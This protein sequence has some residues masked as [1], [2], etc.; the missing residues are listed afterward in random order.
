MVFCDRFIWAE[1]WFFTWS[2]LGSDEALMQAQRLVEA[3]KTHP[4]VS[5]KAAGWSKVVQFKPSDGNPFY[6]HSTGSGLTVTEGL[7]PNPSAT[8]E[9]SHQDLVS[10]LRGE[11]DAVKAFFSGRIK[12][13][14]D[15]FAA[16]ELNSLFSTLLKS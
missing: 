2:G 1:R 5:R 16:Q 14:G 4:E 7:H 11:L 9:S 6:I 3:A 8:V 13:K 12:I 15:V 10:I